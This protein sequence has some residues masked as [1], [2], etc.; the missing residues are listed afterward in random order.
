MTNCSL[1]RRCAGATWHAAGL[2]TR[3]GGSSK[4]K[5]LHVRSLQLLTEIHD[6]TDGGVRL[7]FG[8][9]LVWLLSALP[10]QVGLHLSGS[11]RLVKVGDRDRALEAKHHNELA[12]LYDDPEFPTT[13]L[14]PSEI[15]AL[16][17]LVD[18]SNLELGLRTVSDGDIDPTLLTNALAA[19]AKAY[20]AEVFLG[21]EIEKIEKLATGE[22]KLY[23]VDGSRSPEIADA[24]VNAT[25]LWSQRFSAQMGLVKT[26][27]AFVIEH[28][29]AV[30]EPIEALA[31]L[32][33]CGERVDF[34]VSSEVSNTK[35]LQSAGACASRSSR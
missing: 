22:F 10:S 33:A 19:D 6:K 21:T 27:P 12:K 28:H 26:H 17:P 3:F 11:I 23:F 30:T 31:K 20:G 15:A 24:V 14:T 16:H 34:S 9:A 4:L 7:C 8:L 25:G 18:A 29:Y 5:K 13:L 32:R 2:V 1:S 35:Y